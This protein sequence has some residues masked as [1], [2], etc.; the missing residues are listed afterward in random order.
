[1]KKKIAIIAGGDSGEYSISMKSGEF[2]N[3]ILATENYEPFL[4]QIKGKDWFYEDAGL[5]YAIDKN[6][7]SLKINGEH[8]RFDVVFCAVHGSPGE[9]GKLPA[10]FEMIGIPYTSSDSIT[11]AL[12]FNKNYCNRVVASWGINVANSLQFF[13]EDIIDV[14]NVATSLQLPVFVKPNCGGSSVGMSKVNKAEELESAIEKA[15]QEDTQV[16]I[17]EFVQGRELTCGVV[18]NKGKMIVFP[19]CEIVSKK[20]FFDF[21]AKYKPSL[22]D[23]I[24]PAPI[25]VDTEIEVKGIS[26]FLYKKLN[27]KGVVRFDYI[28]SGEGDLY[29]LEVNTVP[30]LTRESLTPKLAKEMGL[31]MAE[32]FSMMIEDAMLRPAIQMNKGPN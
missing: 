32:L 1:M 14:Q 30:G 28:L 5:K 9:N 25:D 31:S 11:C 6:D 26:S 22:A 13:K 21:E 17:E 19:I 12:T 23:E 18:E 7:F 24:V 20:E 8:I 15:F 29:F 2:V 10:Y 4:I 3:E 27:C 16:L